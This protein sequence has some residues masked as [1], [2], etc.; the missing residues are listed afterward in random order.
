MFVVES[1]SSTDT[2][3]REEFLEFCKKSYESQYSPACVNMWHPDWE[4]RAETLPFLVYKS[5]RF[6]DNGIFFI[7][8]INGKIEAV[9]G[10]YIS[11]FDK[12]VAIGGVRSWTNPGH[13]ADLIIGRHIFPK[14]LKWAK[15]HN[16]KTIALTFNEY[17]KKL[18]RY[19]TRNGLGVVKNR[20][21]DMLFYNGVYEV[22]FP[23]II[24]NTKQWALYHK[25]DETYDPN[26]E[27]I[28][29]KDSI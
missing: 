21:P 22:P 28:R 8:R 23:V 17:N 5:N 20:T 7:L 27:L 1:V 9:S 13:Q 26:W 11:A 25:I 18:M 16:I 14:Q 15:D 29:Y 4:N 3:N 10:I 2:H 19:F 6:S 12:S 24:Q